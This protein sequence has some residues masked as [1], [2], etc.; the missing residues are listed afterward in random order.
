MTPAIDSL[1]SSVPSD[2]SKRCRLVG[3]SL[4]AVLMAVW[5][6]PVEAAPSSESCADVAAT[7][8]P[9][10][11][12][13]SADVVA[14]PSFKP[15]GTPPGSGA[16]A[17]LP[18]FCRVAAVSKPA[19]HFEI[20]LPLA[21]WNGKFQG[22]GNGANAGSIS[23]AAMA[24]AL[25]LGYATAS[26]DTGHSTTNARDA[27][28]AVG[29]PDLVADFGY[30]AVHITTEHAKAVVRRFYG[31]TPSHSYFMACST[32]GLKR[33]GLEQKLYGRKPSTVQEIAEEAIKSWL[34]TEGYL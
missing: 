4:A 15:P 14:G 19:V 18:S 7:A 6:G 28:W 33:A 2:R 26:T 11:T 20:W 10:T 12:I 34:D 27:Q 8:L 25:R 17:G 30:R 3:G 16:L 9:D 13:E 21:G 24:S 31:Q 1:D 22:V 29:R 23:Y 32:G 5:L